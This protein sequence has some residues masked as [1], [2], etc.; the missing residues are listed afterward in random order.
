MTNAQ[1]HSVLS[2]FDRL[3]SLA[4]QLFDRGATT[5]SGVVGHVVGAERAEDG[6]LISTGTHR[7]WVPADDVRL[8][9]S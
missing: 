3:F 1:G 9:S 7:V 6:D 5:R 2:A 4:E 8:G